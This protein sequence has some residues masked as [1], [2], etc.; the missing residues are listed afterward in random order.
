LPESNE[1][2][3]SRVSLEMRAVKLPS[4][5]VDA[6]L[7]QYTWCE[8]Q[9]MNEVQDKC[10]GKIV[11]GP[12]IYKR[13]GCDCLLCTPVL[14][15]HQALETMPRVRYLTPSRLSHREPGSGALLQA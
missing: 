2:F 13:N 7:L 14:V 8:W 5:L 6:I 11:F 4:S 3:S 10:Y 9:P 1:I 12:T 15:S